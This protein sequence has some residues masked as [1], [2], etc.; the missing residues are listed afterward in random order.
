MLVGRELGAVVNFEH[1]AVQLG[2]FLL[3]LLDCKQ[4][5]FFLFF[6]AV[7][8]AGELPDGVL[9]PF[10]GLRVLEEALFAHFFYLLNLYFYFLNLNPH[11][12]CIESHAG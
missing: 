9:A 3:L 2:D 7:Q 6:L 10:V 12:F 1:A 11:H 8:E 5:G 4:E